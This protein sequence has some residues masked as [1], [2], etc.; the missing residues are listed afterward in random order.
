M[1]K[2]IHLRSFASAIAMLMALEFTTLGQTVPFYNIVAPRDAENTEGNSSSIEPF[3]NVTT[4]RRYQQVFDAS[5]FSLVADGGGMIHYIAFRRDGSCLSGGDG[6]FPS[7]QIDLSTTS[8]GPD[9]LSPIF[10]QNVGADDIVVRAA[11]QLVFVPGCGSSPEPFELITLDTPFFYNPKAGNLL[12]DI[13]NYG[14]SGLTGGAA[15]DTENVSGDSV[16]H[17]LA[18]NV[19]S[20]TGQ[21]VNSD[22]LVT[23]FGIQ[24]VPEP[25]TWALLAAGLGCLAFANRRRPRKRSQNAAD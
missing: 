2:R 6:V 3:V 9:S 13:R 12:L 19:I 7:V 14:S 25:S 23:L 22:G 24:A 16:S 10:A 15:L 5:Q 20:D 17:V 18:F 8:K 21:E 4:G 11:R 1:N